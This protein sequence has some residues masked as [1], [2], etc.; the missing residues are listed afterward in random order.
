MRSRTVATQAMSRRTIMLHPI[1]RVTRFVSFIA[2]ALL[3]LG[4][5]TS[6]GDSTSSG[7]TKVSLLLT[8]AP[9]D[10]K[11]AVVTISEIDLQGTGGSQVLLNTPVTVDL[12]TLAG[13]TAQLVKDAVV[14]S[15]RYAQMRFVITG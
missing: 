8:D 5:L 3:A 9:G 13:S 7:T 11:S 2:L 4:T 10:V 15:G 1:T 14:P 12:L 6:C